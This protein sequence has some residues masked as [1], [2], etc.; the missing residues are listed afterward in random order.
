M[1]ILDKATFSNIEHQ[2]IEFVTDTIMP[3]LVRWEQAISR[4]LI[5]QDNTFFAE[6]LIDALL[7]GDTSSRYEA[8][9]SAI[10]NGWMTRNEARI[11]ENMN[12]KPGLDEPLQQLNMANP[13]PGQDE[14][15]NPETDRDNAIRQNAAHRV[16]NKELIAI[17][18]AYKKHLI[19]SKAE[20]FKKWVSNFYSDHCKYVESSMALDIDTAKEYSDMSETTLLYAINLEIEKKEPYVLD[21]LE[22]WQKTKSTELVNL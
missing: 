6:F 12:P 2:G 22:L 7:R 20:E 3:W 17:K 21:L 8:Y 1:G 5:V 10:T 18:R 19:I 11:K 9:A 13:Q 15:S 4:D 14:E 16:V